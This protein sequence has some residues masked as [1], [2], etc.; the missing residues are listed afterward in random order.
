MIVQDSV[1]FKGWNL[2][3]KS[4]NYTY[5][6]LLKFLLTWDK[7]CTENIVV[8]LDAYEIPFTQLNNWVFAY[9]AIIQNIQLILRRKESE[10][11]YP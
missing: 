6:S 3:V 2:H 10:G 5:K 7:L 1:Q 4:M 9:K 8:H 11:T